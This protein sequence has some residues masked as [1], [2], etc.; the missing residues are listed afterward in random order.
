SSIAPIVAERGD[1]WIGVTV[2]AGSV[3]VLKTFDPVRYA[4]LDLAASGYGWD[5]LRDVGALLKSKDPNRPLADLDVK[6]G[7]LGGYS[8]SAV[9]AGTFASGF[10]DVTRQKSGKPVYDGYFIGARGANLSPLQ[11]T[12]ALIPSFEVARLRPLDVPVVDMEP[13]ANAEGFAVE[14]PT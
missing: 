8:Q 9:D 13:Q 10:H 12:G 6:R 7:Y 5:V 2:R 11:S 14:V 4:D 1:A 3:P